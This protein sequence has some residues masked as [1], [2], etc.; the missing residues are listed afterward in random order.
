MQEIIFLVG[1]PGSG[2][3]T[4]AKEKLKNC[5]TEIF[6]S[7]EIRGELYGDE[8]IQKDPALVFK[9]LYSRATEA[10]KSGKNIVIDATSIN[11]QDRKKGLEWFKDFSAYRKAIFL[12]VPFEICLKRD[13]SRQRNVGEGV[14]QKFF[15]GLELPT[16]E[17]GFDEIIIVNN[18]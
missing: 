16:K 17:E 3:S 8:K 2:K 7:D 9:T 10:F 12:N 4:Y 1:A 18:F 6:S 14:L 11:R 13:A 15:D 5:K